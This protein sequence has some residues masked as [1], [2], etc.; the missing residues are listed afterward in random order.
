MTKIIYITLFSVFTILSTGLDAQQRG[1]CGTHDHSLVKRV[2]HNRK[3]NMSNIRNGVVHIPIIFHSTAFNDG[4]NQVSNIAIVRQMQKLNHDYE[5]SN[6]EIVFYIDSINYVHDEDIFLRSGGDL[7]RNK[8]KK[9]KDE[10]GASAMNVFITENA[11]HEGQSLGVTLGYYT[12]ANDWV[13]IR[14]NEIVTQSNTLSHEGGHFYSLPHTFYGWEFGT[15]TEG[16][17]P[18]DPVTL[19]DTVTLVNCPGTSLAIE[20]ASRDINS[21]GNCNTAADLF[22]DTPAD[23]N[24]GFGN[25]CR[26]IYKDNV[27]DKNFDPLDPMINNQM[28]YFDGCDDFQFTGEQ[29]T[30]VKA[31]V[32]S[33][34]RAY[35]RNSYLPNETTITDSLVLLNP[36]EQNANGF[37]LPKYYDEVVI[38]WEAVEGASRYIIDLTGPGINKS[39]IL[40]KGETSYT[41]TDLK[42]KKHYTCTIKPYNDG[43]FNAP[44]ITFIIKTSNTNTAVNEIEQ[45]NSFHLTPNPI[46]QNEKFSLRL[47][48]NTSFE[49][50]VIIRDISGK[51]LKRQNNIY[52]TQGANDVELNTSSLSKGMYLVSINTA[53]GSTTKKLAIQ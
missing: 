22:C 36:T 48:A 38:E 26:F 3:Y 23:W 37:Y 21:G 16:R 2:E 6:A 52:F 40:F 31:D 15:A 35:L 8:M 41:F 18:Y 14:K 19:G 27:W 32:A 34:E 49:A 46:S 30:A 17:V 29:V 39:I 12:S 25:G 20:Q 5:I 53:E 11:D 45:I 50:H 13:V 7:A 42:N 47:E 9:V 28:S 4:K 51:V 10:E 43:F 33:P 44:D 1:V 24:F